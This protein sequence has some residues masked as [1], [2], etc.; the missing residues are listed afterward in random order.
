MWWPYES[1]VWPSVLS[2]QSAQEVGLIW[3]HSLSFLK[4]LSSKTKQV[5][6]Q[7][8]SWRWLRTEGG[9]VSKHTCEML[10][11][12]RVAELPPREPPHVF[13]PPDPLGRANG[14]ASRFSF[15]F[16]LLWITLKSLWG[17][18]PICWVRNHL[19]VQR[20]WFP[21]LSDHSNCR[22]V[23]QT[24]TSPGLF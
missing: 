3:G 10:R 13:R 11:S 9:W 24:Y 1:L 2:P 16:T 22:N 6:F 20:P 4:S 7:A 21:I 5:L 17:T 23:C 18:G 15:Y 8:F 12:A 14:K 19:H